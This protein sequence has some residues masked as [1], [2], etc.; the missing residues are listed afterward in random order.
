MNNWL[1]DS[2]PLVYMLLG[3]AAVILAVVWWRTRR[4]WFLIGTGVLGLLVGSIFL[5][6]A[7]YPSDS[8]QLIHA[9]QDM[10]AAL[11]ARNMDRIFA[12]ISDNFGF[13][14]HAK[15]EFRRL[16]EEVL[17][18]RDVT[19]CV[20]WDFVPEE[21]SRARGT[22]KLSFNV[23]PRGNWGSGAEFYLCKAEFV[24]EADGQWR[25]K[26]FEIFNPYVD[27]SHPM[28]IPGF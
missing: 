21:V 11:H 13:H 1:A 2:A 27:T 12:H 22:G 19:E 17:H 25:M 10:S 20:V 15:P 4:G 3:T 6:R 8:E 9:V 16:C 26:T 14:R 18:R 24:L 7:W 28:D 5:L 23:K